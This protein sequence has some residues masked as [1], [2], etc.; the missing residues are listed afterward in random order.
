MLILYSADFQGLRL[1][2]IADKDLEL[3]R[4]WKNSNRN[5]F[6]YKNKISR[7]DQKKWFQGFLTRSQDYMFM[8]EEKIG[9]SFKPVGCMGFRMDEGGIDLYN[10]IRGIKYAASHVKMGDAL[11]VICSY[12]TQ[13]YKLKI[14]CKVI[15]SN[16]AVHWYKKNGFDII[17][18]QDNYV[19]ME[20]NTSGFKAC[21]VDIVQE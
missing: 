9:R 17:Q 11:H 2:G 14:S 15:G 5:S 1:R 20:L 8:V 16:P 4:R 18:T 13:Y 3:L 10:I 6:F 19:V 21:E 12:V 7:K